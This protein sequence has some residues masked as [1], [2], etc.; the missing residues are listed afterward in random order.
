MSKFNVSNV[1]NNKTENL[2]GHVAYKMED[3][4]KLVTQVLTS[5]FGEQ[6]FYGY[7]TNSM[8][9]LAKVVAAN[10]PSFVCNL[11]RYARK[12]I[13]MRSVSHAL[14][15]I[16]ANSVQGKEFVKLSCSDVIVRADDITEILACYISMF[17]KPIPNSLKKALGSAMNKFNEFQFSKYNGG[18]KAVKFRDVLCICHAKPINDEKSLLFKKIL[19]DE[20]AVAERWETE[21]SAKGNTKEVW[22]KLIAEN[23]LGYMAALRNLRNI[24]NSGA[25][26]IDKIYDKLSDKD[27]VLKSKQ[28]PFRFYSAYKSIKDSV[29]TTNKVTDVL[30]KAVKHSVENMP[31]IKGKTVIAIDVSGSMSWGTISKSEMK[32][33]DIA[34]LLGVIANFICDETIVCCFDTNIYKYNV[35]SNC[36][37]LSETSR[38]VVNGGG[39]DLTLPLRVLLENNIAVDRIIILSDNEINFR[40]ERTCQHLVNKYRREINSN[41]WV[42]AIDLQGYGTQQFIGEKTNIIAGWSEKILDFINLAEKGISNQVKLIKNY[43]C[44]ND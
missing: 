24:I 19:N 33:S 36:N 29:L 10:E 38:L 35:P 22:E 28:L 42:H 14:V 27:E 2:S 6:K 44:T 9:E 21:L 8:V 23:K 15:A 3:K 1:G 41:F 39:T 32:A 7:N 12:E 40:F 5:F 13:H 26:N 18:N 31:K 43:N 16:L 37:I 11:A 30:E 20:L 17:G 25:L 4:E 34:C